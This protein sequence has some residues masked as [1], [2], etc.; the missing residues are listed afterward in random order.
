MK[1]SEIFKEFD[2]EVKYLTKDYDDV[3]R[4]WD[5]LPYQ[6]IVD[7]IGNRGWWVVEQMGDMGVCIDVDNVDEF[8]NLDWKDC[9]IGREKYSSDVST[10]TND[11]DLT[12]LC[13]QFVKD[14]E[15]DYVDEGKYV[16]NP[17]MMLM[18]YYVKFKQLLQK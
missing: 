13:E 17:P 5:K 18:D 9:I 15:L 12:K 11:D 4:L 16:D 8:D 14:F 6:V 3:F 7:N 10:K 2:G 1:A